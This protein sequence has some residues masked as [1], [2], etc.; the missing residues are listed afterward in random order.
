MCARLG[1]P[2]PDAERFAVSDRQPERNT[3]ADQYSDGN[4]YT[5]GDSNRDT[6]SKADAVRDAH[7]SATASRLADA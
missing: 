1:V 3:D 6:D 4:A 7:S 5:V 2:R